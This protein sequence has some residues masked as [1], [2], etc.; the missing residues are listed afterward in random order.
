MKLSENIEDVIN[1]VGKL[2][3]EANSKGYNMDFETVLINLE[4]KR[5]AAKLYEDLEESKE[6]DEK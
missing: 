4:I 5:T 1:L 3:A 6:L 2:Q